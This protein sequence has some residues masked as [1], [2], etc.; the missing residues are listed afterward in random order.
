M[1]TILH[2]YAVQFTFFSFKEFKQEY[3]SENYDNLLTEKNPHT[4][5]LFITSPVT[6]PV[7]CLFQASTGRI[8]HPPAGMVVLKILGD[9]PGLLAGWDIC[10]ARYC[11]PGT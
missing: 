9:R 6:L 1:P 2:I 8:L 7:W 11:T 3:N 10:P 5:A 4:L